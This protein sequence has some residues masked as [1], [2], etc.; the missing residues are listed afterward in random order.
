LTHPVPF[1]TL[2]TMCASPLDLGF[3]SDVETL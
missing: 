2:P 1:D 3:G